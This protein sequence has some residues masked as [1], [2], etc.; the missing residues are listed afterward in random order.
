MYLALG[1]KVPMT[2]D[3]KFRRPEVGLLNVT[4]GQMVAALSYW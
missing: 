1:G 3:C 2:L 4:G